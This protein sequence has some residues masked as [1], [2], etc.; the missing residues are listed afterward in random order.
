MIFISMQELKDNNSLSWQHSYNNSS[1]P[2][3][4]LK[5]ISS[6][7]PINPV[8]DSKIMSNSLLVFKHILLASLKFINI[9]QMRKHADLSVCRTQGVG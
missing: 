2:H 7:I 6:K 3:R 8:L 9:A 1:L 5:F 4:Y